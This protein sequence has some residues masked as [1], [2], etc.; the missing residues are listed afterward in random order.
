M[1]YQEKLQEKIHKRLAQ[2]GESMPLQPIVELCSDR[3][4]W[5]ENH[6]GVRKYTQQ[7]ILVCV[8]YGHLQ[9]IGNHL[10]VCRMDGAMLVITGHV[11]S[12]HVRKERI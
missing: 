12:I 6:Q 10:K 2:T 9:I 11:Q 4:I 3:R 7:E 8:R 1:K 5:I